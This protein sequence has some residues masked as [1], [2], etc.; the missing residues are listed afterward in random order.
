MKK[1][2]FNAYVKYVC[3]GL[4]VKKSDIFKKTREEK[5]LNARWIL[6]LMCYQRP[7][8][9]LQ[10][11]DLMSENG[12]VTSRQNIENGISRLTELNDPDVESFIYNGVEL[13]SHSDVL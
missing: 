10:I 8:T 7:M 6:W 5:I 4:D 12:Y 9:I 2:I 1:G 11:V 13:Y 3:K